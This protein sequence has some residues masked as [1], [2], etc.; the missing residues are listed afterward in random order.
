MLREIVLKVIPAPCP[1]PGAMHKEDRGR[2][3]GVRCIGNDFELHGVS[4]PFV[5]QHKDVTHD[6]AVSQYALRMV[7]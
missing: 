7:L 5:E 1:K 6:I 4:D 2:T 3:S